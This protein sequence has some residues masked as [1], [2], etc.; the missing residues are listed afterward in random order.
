MCSN[1][2]ITT[3]FLGIFLMVTLLL[4]L[5]GCGNPSA[6]FIPRDSQM[7]QEEQLVACQLASRTRKAQPDDG[8]I[9]EGDYVTFGSYR[10]DKPG[11]PIIWQV[12]E[13]DGNDALLLSVYGLDTL[14]YHAVG[15]DITWKDCSLRKWL[16]EDFYDKAFSREEQAN[17]L[18]A[19]NTADENPRYWGVD[20]GKDT[21][22]LVFILSL[23]EL[24][25]YLGDEKDDLFCEPTEYAVRKNGF[26][27]PKTGGCWYW[28][29]TPGK[30]AEHACSINA[31][32]SIDDASASVS[33]GHGCIRPALWVSLD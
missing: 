18:V 8:K 32:G 24:E 12:L 15:G 7:A 25:Y 33:S 14:P 1:K 21:D 5:T 27:E 10:Q 9:H 22:D 31:D 30:S 11:D 17:I 20:P 29:R 6:A 28:V 26:R 2:K 16:N 4:S 19:T 3:R 23:S 13:I